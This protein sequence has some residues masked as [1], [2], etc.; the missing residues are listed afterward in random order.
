VK[1]AHG[2]RSRHLILL[3]TAVLTAA[4]VGLV[5]ARPA[6]AS[7]TPSRQASVLAHRPAWLHC[8]PASR[9]SRVGER[10]L[11]FHRISVSRLSS[12]D[13]AR[14]KADLARM[15]AQARSGRSLH[16][17][18][19][20]AS[21]PAI[22]E[23][24]N[25]IT[26]EVDGSWFP[27]R[28]TSCADVLSQLISC[29]VTP[30][31]GCTVTGYLNVE[32]FQWIS[33]TG[34]DSTW[35]HG[36]VTDTY[37]GS[38]DLASGFDA[39][40][41]S[42]CTGAGGICAAVSETSPDPQTVAMAQNSEYR[43][44]WLEADEGPATTAADQT[45]VLDTILGMIWIASLPGGAS[46][47][48]Q[49]QGFGTSG[50]NTESPGL[51]GRCDSIDTPGDVCVD[52]DNIPIL[53]LS[54]GKDGASAAMVEWAQENEQD[55]W[56]L[57]GFG[58]PM[59]Y[60]SDKQ[61]QQ[62]NTSIMCDS[63]FIS[64]GTAI[65][66]DDGSTDSCDEFPFK[67]TFESAPQQGLGSGAECDQVTAVEVPVAQRTGDLAADWNAVQPVGTPTQ[68]AQCVR[69]H[70]PL[71]LNSAVGSDFGIFVIKN[72]MLQEDQFWVSVIA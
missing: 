71:A 56:G 26:A 63:T 20:P 51:V 48:F 10:C 49:D 65:G 12:A 28:F 17:R 50:Q 52:E 31:G 46:A 42:L 58:N 33:Y 22:V 36:M 23:P 43:F 47:V 21:G 53:E 8:T 57:A 68:I 9:G 55:H 39:E 4:L 25:C 5:N 2:N 34:T 37:T 35:T 61:A 11:G 16:V 30:S 32:D 72:R 45:D 60:L 67:A 38:G 62:V 64:Q 69:G 13:R 3:L 7:A 40:A 54:L 1:H 19:A 27:D 41:S 14:R 6:V 29:I 59:T 24:P 44:E 66:G 18:N 15:A 70:I